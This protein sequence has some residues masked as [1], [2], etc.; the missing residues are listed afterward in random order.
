MLLLQDGSK[1]KVASMLALCHMGLQQLN[2]A[3]EYVE[4]SEQYQPLRVCTSFIRFKI[5]LEQQEEAK[6]LAE[7]HHMISCVDFEADMLQVSVCVHI[8]A[9]TIGCKLLYPCYSIHVT[10][11]WLAAVSAVSYHHGACSV[12]H[13]G[14]TTASST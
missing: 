1:D 9:H 14:T 11:D 10:Y 12:T 4:L 13:M 7:L 5:L 6:A 8:H 3:L 2:H